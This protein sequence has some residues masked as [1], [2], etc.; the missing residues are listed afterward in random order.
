MITSLAKQLRTSNL[1]QFSQLR[2]L[3][4]QAAALE[5]LNLK[6]K[7]HGNKNVPDLFKNSKTDDYVSLK[8][9]DLKNLL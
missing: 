9:I 3:S 8:L 7:F 5:K 2:T 6:K 1:I 4:T